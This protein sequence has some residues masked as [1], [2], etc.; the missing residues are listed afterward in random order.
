MTAPVVD[1]LVAWLIQSSLEACVLIGL[2][3]ATQVVLRGKLSAGWRHAL[4]LLL[5]AHVLIPWR[6]SSVW[7][8]YNVIPQEW[9]DA[10]CWT[11]PTVSDEFDVAQA[12]DAPTTLGRP[13]PRPPLD[14]TNAF[15]MTPT[16]SRR[17]PIP[18]VAGWIWLVGAAG[19]GGLVLRRSIALL[20]A[21]RRRPF[22]T[23]AKIDDLIEQCK[24]R[25]GCRRE[26][27]VLETPAVSGPTW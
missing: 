13:S 7:S 2:V 3:L 20:L 9:S 26:V 1:R 12:V 15:S 17:L 23:D 22:V 24:R 4:W 21:V 6:P 16:G 25:M 14:H 11:A 18:I 27:R 5:L 10:V 19:L 8:V